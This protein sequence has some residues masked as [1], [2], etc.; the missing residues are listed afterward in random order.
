MIFKETTT[1]GL[2]MRPEFRSVLAREE[3]VCATSFGP[4]R[5]K[6]AYGADGTLIK[7]HIEYEDVRRIA[8]E[9]GLPYRRLLDALKKEL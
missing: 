7:S 2:R 8:D 4:V 6:Q 5:V 3:Q 9:K 1:F